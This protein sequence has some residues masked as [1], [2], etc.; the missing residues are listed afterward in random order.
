MLVQSNAGI[1]EKSKGLE[2]SVMLYFDMAVVFELFCI[3]VFDLAV[4]KSE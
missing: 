1:C 4:S 3:A 2:P